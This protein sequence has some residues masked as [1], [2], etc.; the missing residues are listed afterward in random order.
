[1][2]QEYSDAY[3]SAHGF[4]PRGDYERLRSLSLDA[5]YEAKEAMWAYADE[6]RERERELAAFPEMPL[7][8]PGWQV[9]AGD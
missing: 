7:S 5:L 4:R 1:M 6:E 8:G 9:V 3:K 2:L